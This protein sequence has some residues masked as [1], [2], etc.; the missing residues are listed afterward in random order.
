VACETYSFFCCRERVVN[1]CEHGEGTLRVSIKC[2]DFIR[3]ARPTQ[4]LSRPLAIQKLGYV[5]TY[6]QIARQYCNHTTHPLPL[7][8]LT[9]T[10]QHTQTLDHKHTQP[11]HLKPP[12]H[13]P[14]PQP[15]EHKPP[16]PTQT[17]LHNTPQTAVLN[18]YTTRHN[19]VAL[20][21]TRTIPTERPPPVGEV[22]A[23][24]CG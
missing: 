14:L 3:L 11:Q 21:R 10:L 17:D 24:F 6:L 18:T 13:T 16:V 12:P 1:S 9:T 8:N 22:S 7:T 15:S 5:K 20:V 2:G 23:N 4:R 19:S